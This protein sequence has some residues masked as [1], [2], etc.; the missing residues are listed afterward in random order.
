MYDEDDHGRPGTVYRVAWQLVDG[1]PDLHSRVLRN[2]A[3]LLED[4]GDA[5]VQVEVIA[6]GAG[7]DLLLATGQTG[8]AIASLQAR[9]VTFLACENT[10]RGRELAP[11]DLVRDVRTV[12]SGVGALVRRQAEGWSYLRA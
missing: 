7:L 5:G 2:V 6:H 12:P 3:N 1:A 9:G 4:L 10:L 11:S 8:D